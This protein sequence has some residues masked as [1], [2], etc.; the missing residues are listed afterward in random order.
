VI[1]D[2]Q[3]DGES[4]AQ[5]NSIQMGVDQ[6]WDVSFI[7]P[8]Q[9][10]TSSYSQIAGDEMVFVLD[11]NGMGESKIQARFANNN[12]ETA[13]ENLHKIGI[14]Y[15]YQNDVYSQLIAQSSQVNFVRL[16]SGGMVSSPLDVTYSW[17]IPRLG[18]YS[19]RGIDIKRTIGAVSGVSFDDSR[20]FLRQSGQIGSYLEGSIF[21]QALFS[22]SGTG[23]SSMHVLNNANQQDIPIYRIDSI[24]QA[25]V[26]PL[27]EYSD[28]D[29]MSDIRN[30]LAVGFVVTVPKKKP[31]N[32]LGK[33]QTGYILEDPQTGAA[34]YRISSGL[35]GGEGE[36]P[37]AEPQSE[38]LTQSISAQ[39]LTFVALAMIAAALVALAPA[40]IAG[41][42]VVARIVAQVMA[43]LGLTFLTFSATAGGIC[44]PIAVGYHKGGD[45]IHDIC[46]DTIP[47]NEVFGSDWCLDG[48]F[49][50]AKRGNALW[51][52]KTQNWARSNPFVR[53]R[54]IEGF[55]EEAEDDAS[56]ARRC[57]FTY[58]FMVGDARYVEMLSVRSPNFVPQFADNLSVGPPSCIQP[59]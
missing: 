43:S 21:E 40:A 37:C 50:D 34:S 19:K 9:T 39:I 23:A 35:D 33:L 26:L 44:Q 53:G 45:P 58:T 18:S 54:V 51:E 20:E 28:I 3:L 55:I 30:A 57:G 6:Y 48:E 59:E 16:P 36:A 4:I 5:S 24:N 10:N 2:I 32:V 41:G 8:Y 27:L 52:V 49:F 14:Q 7:S 13:A 42:V 25:A 29:V 38:P 22:W 1:A 12:E 17:G 56:I 31:T 11:A 46:A 47:P 15:W